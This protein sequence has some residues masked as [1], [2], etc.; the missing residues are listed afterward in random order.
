MGEPSPSCSFQLASHTPLAACW[1][2]VTEWQDLAGL[3]CG[4]PA[5]SAPRTPPSSHQP[6]ALCGSVLHP[7]FA[8]LVPVHS[9]WES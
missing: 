8:T 1:L 7:G 2:G 6:S 4:Q 5:F 3:G 9:I